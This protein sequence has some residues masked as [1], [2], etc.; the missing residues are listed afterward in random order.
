MSISQELSELEK[1]AIRKE[2]IE[3]MKASYDASLRALYISKIP[4]DSRLEAVNV[5]FED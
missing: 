1:E 4:E 5:D 3:K 2:F